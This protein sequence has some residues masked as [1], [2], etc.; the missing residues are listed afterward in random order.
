MFGKIACY[1]RFIGSCVGFKLRQCFLI[2][3]ICLSIVRRKRNVFFRFRSIK[4]L[5][6]VRIQQFYIFF[7]DRIFTKIIEYIDNNNK[8]PKP[9]IWT[10]TAEEILNKVNRARATLY[11]MQSNY[12]NF[13]GYSEINARAD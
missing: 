10:K 5:F 12:S 11:N 3:T 13:S 1:F 8:D 7:R 9:F 2:D 6:Y 4:T